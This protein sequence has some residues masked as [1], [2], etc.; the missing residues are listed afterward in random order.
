MSFAALS[1]RPS[2]CIMHPNSSVRC[3]RKTDPAEVKRGL[4]VSTGRWKIDTPNRVAVL[5][6]SLIKHELNFYCFVEDESF[7]TCTTIWLTVG[8]F[9]FTFI[10]SIRGN[11]TGR[12]MSLVKGTLR[13]YWVLLLLIY[14][15]WKMYEKLSRGLISHTIPVQPLFDKLFKQW[16]E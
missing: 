14:F 11:L 5:A 10:Q 3:R 6:G 13:E 2:P 15:A 8:G 9:A 16:P 12:T 1:A 4:R 7:S